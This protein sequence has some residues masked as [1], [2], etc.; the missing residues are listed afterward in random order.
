MAEGWFTRTNLPRR[1]KACGGET[2]RQLPPFG[3]DPALPALM[4]ET[5]RAGAIQA[6]MPTHETALLLAAHGSK[7]SKTSANGTWAMVGQMR[8]LAGFATVSA[9]FVEE[10]PFLQAA[11]TGLGHAVCLPFFALSAGHITDDVPEA[12]A[13]AG[14]AGVLLPPIGEAAGTARLIAAAL[15][16]A[17]AS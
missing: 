12:L 1:L 2:L 10:A 14:F 15:Q 8:D 6:E 13:A 11:A 17:V 4:A 3:V 16:R 9:G 5:A 7:V